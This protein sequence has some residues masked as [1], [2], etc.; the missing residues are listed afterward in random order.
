V[1][2]RLKRGKYADFVVLSADPLAV[3]PADLKDLRVSATIVGARPLYCAP[4][5]EDLC[6][7]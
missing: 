4:G 3:D 2:G 6:G 5:S 1:V 7:P